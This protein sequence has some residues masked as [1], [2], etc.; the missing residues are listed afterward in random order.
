MTF[1]DLADTIERLKADPRVY[2]NMPIEIG[3]REE[4]IYLD[5]DGRRD[6]VWESSSAP[7]ASISLTAHTLTL[8]TE[9]ERE[10]VGR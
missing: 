9:N 6:S 5:P 4:T 10:A 2:P 7:L 8:S 3:Y 1:Q